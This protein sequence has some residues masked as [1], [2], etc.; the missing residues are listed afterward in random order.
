MDMVKFKKPADCLDT[1]PKKV[2]ILGHGSSLHQY[3]YDVIMSVDKK[4]FDEVWVVNYLAFTT[5]HDKLFAMDDF[6]RHENRVPEYYDRL[7]QHDRPII[8]SAA[9]PEYPMTVAYP[10]RKVIGKLRDDFINNTVAYAL[11]YA[12][13]IEV[14]DVSMYGCDFFYRDDKMHEE[15]GQSVCWL[16]GLSREF[17]TTVHLPRSTTLMSMDTIVPNG[18]DYSRPLYGYAKQPDLSVPDPV[19]VKLPSIGDWDRPRK[20]VNAKGE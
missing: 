3:F 13:T 14:G 8:T 19:P 16:I 1:R 7:K 12:L 4:V 17:G 5:Q 18:K 15:G 9:Y 20:V 6:H 11:A 10:I 2:A